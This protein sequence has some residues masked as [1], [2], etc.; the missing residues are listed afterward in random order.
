MASVWLVGEHQGQG[1]WAAGYRRCLET[2]VALR[3][4]WKVECGV[5]CG[6]ILRVEHGARRMS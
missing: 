1:S 4:L 5:L 6:K 3:R 2:M